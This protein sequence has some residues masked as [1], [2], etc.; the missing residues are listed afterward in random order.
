MAHK[1]SPAGTLTDRVDAEIAQIL[2]ELKQGASRMTSV[3]YDTAWLARLAGPFPGRGF[4]AALNWL[5]RSQHKDGSWGGRIL[6]YHDRIV[7]TLAAIIALRRLGIGGEDE[8]RI[9]LGEAFLWRENGR[10]HHDAND[11]IGF[12]ILALSLVNEALEVG[13]DIPRDLYQD[14]AKIEKKL[15]MLGHNPQLWRYTTLIVS[16]EAVRNY[17]TD[18]TDFIEAN[19][20]VGT[21][22]AATVATLLNSASPDSRSLTYLQEVMEEQ[23]DGGAP[24]VKPFDIFEPLWTLNHF[25]LSEAI[26]PDHPEVQRILDFVWEMWSPD[27][28][29]SYSPYFH[30]PDL[31]DT[32]VAFVLLKWGG[33]PVDANVF[34]TYEHDQHFCCYP[35]ELDQSLS[36]NI[37]TLAALQMDKQHPQV[38]AW[39]RKISAMLRRSDLT[40]YFWFDKWHMSPYYLTSTAIWSLHGVVDDLLPSRI[41]WIVRT[42]RDDG[43]WGYYHQSTVE[44]TAY[45]LQ[46]LLFWDR[47]TQERVESSVIHAAANY[48]VQHLE[49]DDLPPLWIGKSLYTPTNVVR[50]AILAA[51]YSY[52]EYNAGISMF[53]QVASKRKLKD[54]SKSLSQNGRH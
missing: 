35:G 43:G 44:E 47:Y 13:L 37:R 6:H 1:P 48:L 45:C 36:V 4:E 51:L 20:S 34:K 26:S 2:Q 33:Y 9:Q 10:L 25:R 21:S 8:Q 31:D 27:K 39:T 17:I 3:A 5:R 7:C 32:A 38:E 19:G 46:A 40:G 54:V 28:G 14:V 29:L 52:R 42:Q 41:K 30:V 11:T 16:L 50:S 22:P 23:G 12:P 24:F 49:A 53:S 18:S 15:N